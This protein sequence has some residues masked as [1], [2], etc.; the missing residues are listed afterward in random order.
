MN[1]PDG[2][3]ERYKN[4]R[5]RKMFEKLKDLNIGDKVKFYDKWSQDPE[6][7]SGEGIIEGFGRFG[8]NNLIWIRL[9]DGRLKGT[10]YESVEKI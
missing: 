9:Q 7:V 3:R 2:C 6:M 10:V 8:L 4:E 1:I 5:N